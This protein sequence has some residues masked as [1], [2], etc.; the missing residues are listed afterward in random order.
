MNR[1]WYS[2]R[3]SRRLTDDW[4]I[5]FFFLLP[6]YHLLRLVNTLLL[7]NEKAQG[8]FK[9]N[10]TMK[11]T[12]KWPLGVREESRRSEMRGKNEGCVR[13]RCQCQTDLHKRQ[14]KKKEAQRDQ[15]AARTQLQWRGSARAAV[16]WQC[17][18]RKVLQGVNATLGMQANASALHVCVG[19]KCKTTVNNNKHCCPSFFPHVYDGVIA[20]NCG[21]CRWE[22]TKWTFKSGLFALQSL[23]PWH[24]FQLF[25]KWNPTER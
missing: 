13:E 1:F 16:T 5:F 10:K 14:T 24:G 6:F 9:V 18:A 2:V 7:V 23:H 15:S 11:S 8:H 19:G 22:Q 21:L 12:E 3:R 4:R 17:R 25:L 20:F